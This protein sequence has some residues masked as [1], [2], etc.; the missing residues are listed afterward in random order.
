M[1][2]SRPYRVLLVEDDAAD[3]LLIEEALEERGVAREVRR[4]SDGVDALDQLHQSSASDHP[5]L[6][7]LDLNM[8]RMNG[9]EFLAQ[10]KADPQLR[11]IPVVVLTTSEAPGD[12]AGAYQNYANAYVRKPVDLDE[13]GA[14]VQR[15]D[16]FFLDTAQPHRP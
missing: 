16:T 15:I 12:I 10:V 9:R 8:P 14:A 6:I 7:V 4:A 13:F 3:A 11:A 1:I 5:D 2:A